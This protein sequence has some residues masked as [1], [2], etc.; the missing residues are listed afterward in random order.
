M[1]NRWQQQP[2]LLDDPLILE[3]KKLPKVIQQLWYR[4]W[5]NCATNP[6]IS[7]YYTNTHKSQPEGFRSFAAWF[8]RSEVIIPLQVDQF[9]DI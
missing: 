9:F 6:F 3:K 5:N 2:H 8:V 1:K 7:D 4:Y